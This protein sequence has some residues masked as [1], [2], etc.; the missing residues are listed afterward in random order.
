MRSQ[1]KKS[2]KTTK[3]SN[4]L[5][6]LRG[7]ARNINNELV[8]WGHG[9]L[10][11]YAKDGNLKEV[12]L[13]LDKGADV[14]IQNKYGSTAL[15]WAS[16]YGQLK[17]V[18]LLLERGSNVNIQNK[19]GNTALIFASENG[20]LKEVQLLL[21]K[22][23]D[24]NIQTKSGSTALILASQYGQL[25][26]VQ[27][28]LDKGADVN[29][30][31]KN[32]ATVLLN[33]SYYGHLEIVKLL[34]DKGANIQQVNRWGNSALIYASRNDHLE[35]V[36]LLL[37][38]DANIDHVNKDGNS[39]LI[40]ASRNGHLEIVKLLK[41]HHIKFTT[42]GGD[43]FTLGDLNIDFS[44]DI[45]SIEEIYTAI[46]NSDNEVCKYITTG[47]QSFNIM[48]N[49][50]V[51]INEVNIGLTKNYNIVF[52]DS[53]NCDTYNNDCGGCIASKKCK[54]K[55]YGKLKQKTKKK[56]G[57]CVLKSHK[58]KNNSKYIMN[59]HGQC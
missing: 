29:I 38:K 58:S 10:I 35:I 51:T 34:L 19:D 20:N 32:G 25:K 17:V 1:K 48:D 30:E 14:N 41:K 40:L 15:I 8:R 2:I 57:K 59:N 44:R 37:E 54:Y 33:A 12:Q 21:D 42:L 13:L 16:K 3:K 22:G 39:A 28:L 24:V 36:R 27:L 53:S 31:N 26:V 5:R 56:A 23:A 43:S 52:V 47:P 45:I 9:R 46:Y 11:N 18:Q 4:K 55:K 6:K 49:K 7:G 50:G